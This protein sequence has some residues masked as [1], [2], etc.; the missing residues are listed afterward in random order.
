MK[1]IYLAGPC[2]AVDRAQ[3]VA[4]SQQL[5]G[6]AFDVYC[7]F[8]LKIPNAWDMPQ[9]EWAKK[10]FDADKAAIDGSDVIVIIS[11]GR[12]STAGTNWEQG[13]AYALGKPVYVFQITDKTTSLMT[14]WGCTV[15]RNT[16][17]GSV[18]E[19]LRRILEDGD[20]GRKRCITVLT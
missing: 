8:E 10:V 7:P 13:Y 14:Y 17:I 6:M 1:K 12:E 2:G 20:C 4:I 5:R 11:I 15:F 16:E 19:E 3:M 18:G 9:E